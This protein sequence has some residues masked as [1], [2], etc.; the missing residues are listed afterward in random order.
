M[1]TNCEILDKV[2]YIL[3]NILFATYINHCTNKRLQKHTIRFSLYNQIQIESF[4][5]TYKLLTSFKFI[6]IQIKENDKKD[7]EFYK[8][9]SDKWLIIFLELSHTLSQE[10]YIFPKDIKTSYTNTIDELNSLHNYLIHNTKLKEN[11]ETHFDGL[12]YFQNLK[13]DVEQNYIT[14]L[15]DKMQKI[16]KDDLFDSVIKKVEILRNK[17]ELEFEKM[18]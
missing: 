3:V 5:K 12:E 16:N 17:I 14:E 7:F 9:I 11:F 8:T 1:I 13:P 18:N 10:K 4:K 15:I 6:T 2:F